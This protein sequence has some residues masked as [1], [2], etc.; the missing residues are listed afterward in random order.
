M[1]SWAFRCVSACLHLLSSGPNLLTTAEVGGFSHLPTVVAW[2]HLEEEHGKEAS[3]Y[4]PVI[5]PRYSKTMPSGDIPGPKLFNYV[6]LYPSLPSLRTVTLLEGRVWK[7]VL[8]YLN[9]MLSCST[10]RI[11]WW[12]SVVGVTASAGVS[13]GPRC[14][15]GTTHVTEIWIMWVIWAIYEC[16]M[17][18]YD[19]IC[20]VCFE[21]SLHTK[22][23]QDQQASMPSMAL[24]SLANRYQFH[25]TTLYCP[26]RRAEECPRPPEVKI[27]SAWCAHICRERERARGEWG[28]AWCGWAY[29]GKN[30]Y[31]S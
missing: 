7:W 15:E 31:C 8:S 29:A 1:F 3:G 23:L 24:K 30:V 6:W 13:G 21:T 28:R 19:S 9:R 5:I 12:A 4:H 27:K 2:A 11:C 14:D 18:V 26:S 10:S 20:T 17:I 22:I 25:A 16:I